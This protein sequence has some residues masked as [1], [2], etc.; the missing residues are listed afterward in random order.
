[1]A[2]LQLIFFCF[3]LFTGN[4]RN[5]FSKNPPTQM[6]LFQLNFNRDFSVMKSFISSL[7][8]TVF[9]P[10]FLINQP[11]ENATLFAP[12][13]VRHLHINRHVTTASWSSGVST[14][15]E[16]EVSRNAGEVVRAERR[17][18]AGHGFA[19]LHE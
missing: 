14:A 2:E 15:C 12:P 5:A 17:S 9:Q 7:S 8:V 19:C 10:T 3:F 18:N 13:P 1:M 11:K 4:F 16:S 6:V